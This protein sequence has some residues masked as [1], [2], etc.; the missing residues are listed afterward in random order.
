M[1]DRRIAVGERRLRVPVALD[2]LFLGLHVR[3]G[4]G[5]QEPPIVREHASYPIG[6]M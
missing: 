4:A 3:T 1:V 6:S 2:R 5:P